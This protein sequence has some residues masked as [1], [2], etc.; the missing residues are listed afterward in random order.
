MIE[1]FVIGANVAPILACRW[2]F[3]AFRL[4][5]LVSTVGS[6]SDRKM[7]DQAVEG[8]FQLFAA[9]IDVK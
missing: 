3:S 2:I 1:I 9:F 4:G 5:F 7:A 8:Q 6:A